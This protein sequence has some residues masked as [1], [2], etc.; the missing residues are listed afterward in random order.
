MAED[1]ENGSKTTPSSDVSMTPGQQATPGFGA[2][3][4]FNI[5]TAAANQLLS[6]ASTTGLDLL[7]DTL[8]DDAGGHLK[9][10]HEDIVGEYVDEYDTVEL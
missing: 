9:R 2:S 6:S 4:I 1:N 5:A 7:S 10:A 3:L 8:M